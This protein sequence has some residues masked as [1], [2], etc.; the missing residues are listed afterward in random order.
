MNKFMKWLFYFFIW[1]IGERYEKINSCSNDF[2]SYYFF[3]I[4]K[5]ENKKTSAL[6]LINHEEKR[7]VFISYIELGEFIKDKDNDTNKANI[8][9]TLDN[10]K[11]NNF[12]IAILHVRPFSDVI[13]KSNIY[14]YS[15]YISTSEGINPRYDVLEYFIE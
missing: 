1:L 13:Y 4:K 15:S 8:I 5:Y 14:S 9:T 2:C 10:M 6:I 12:N 7:V 11:D 3:I